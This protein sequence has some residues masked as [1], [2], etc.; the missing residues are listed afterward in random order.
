MKVITSGFPSLWGLRD[1]CK[2]LECR[3]LVTF[4]LKATSLSKHGH[5]LHV[6]NIKKAKL[7]GMT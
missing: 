2:V 5:D 7:V 4:E 6:T 3:M 1:L